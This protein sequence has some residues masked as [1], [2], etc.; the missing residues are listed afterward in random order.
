VENTATALGFGPQNQ[1]V[2]DTATAEVTQVPPTAPTGQ[3]TPTD[4]SCSDFR[5]GTSGDL[6]DL[7]YKVKGGEINNVAEGVMFYY[8]EIKAPSSTFKI[9]VKQFNNSSVPAWNPIA[10]QK[11][12]QVILWDTAC[13]KTKTVTPMFNPDNGTVTIDVEDATSGGFA[14]SMIPVA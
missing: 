12:G 2:S 11:I 3:I 10:I 5:D 6:T 13:S 4:T 1:E 14:S 8:S 9:E 7:F